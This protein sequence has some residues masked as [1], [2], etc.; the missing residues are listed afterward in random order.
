MISI[1]QIEMF[2]LNKKDVNVNLW[3]VKHTITISSPAS[4]TVNNGRVG[5][6]M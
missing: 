3:D 2:F 1:T 4:F 6:I 5:E